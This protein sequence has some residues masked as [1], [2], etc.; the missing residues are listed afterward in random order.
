MV[1]KHN[2]LLQAQR[3]EQFK[4]EHQMNTIQSGEWEEAYHK[5]IVFME[6][7]NGTKK[8]C[9]SGLMSRKVQKQNLL[10]IHFLRFNND[11]LCKQWQTTLYSRTK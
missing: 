11:P 2:S 10:F 1:W 9:E 4:D 6:N 8:A 3:T 5:T 7:I